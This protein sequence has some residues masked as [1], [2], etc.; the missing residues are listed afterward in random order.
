MLEHFAKARVLSPQSRDRGEPMRKSLTALAAAIIVLAGVAAP[1]T[2]DARW[3]GGWGGPAIG[4]FAVRALAGI[5]FAPA[6]YADPAYSYRNPAYGYGVPVYCY[7]YP[8]YYGFTS[9]YR[10]FYGKVHRSSFVYP[11][12]RS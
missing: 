11:G 2:A 8:T 7:R 1:T 10:S 3:R 4:G 6:Y 5:A 12:A 9:S